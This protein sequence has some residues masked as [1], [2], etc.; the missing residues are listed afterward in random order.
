MNNGKKVLF[1]ILRLRCQRTPIFPP[2]A[3]R[4]VVAT[5]GNG[6]VTLSWEAPVSSGSSALASYQY[7]YTYRASGRTRSSGWQNA[8]N[9]Q[10]TSKLVSSLTNG[11]AYSFQVRARNQTLEG[12]ASS[13]VSAT[14]KA[15]DLPP[16]APRNVVATA[17]NGQVTLSWEAPV[18]S[19]SSALASYQYKYTY[20]DSGRPRSS[21][22][23]NAGN[24][25]STSRLVSSLTNGTAY[26][27]QVRARNQ[28]LEG[29]ASSSV[30]ATPK[31]SDLPPTAPRN[32]VATAGN[33]QVTLTLDGPQ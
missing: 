9:S 15:S 27:F 24:S 21:G 33:G 2:T 10:S 7:Q 4:N 6:Q 5:A 3:P 13:S 17:G 8:G 30:S 1:P 11:T 16:T 12:T 26:S 19:G 32:V 28:T 31:A 23:Q 20:S 14:P 25:Q 22:W 29:A 18:S